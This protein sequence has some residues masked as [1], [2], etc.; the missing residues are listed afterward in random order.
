MGW[1]E[2][3]LCVVVD[4]GGWGMIDGRDDCQWMSVSPGTG[5]PG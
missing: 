5:S 4:D 2:R 3:M 1:V